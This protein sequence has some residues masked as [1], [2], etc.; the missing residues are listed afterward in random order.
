MPTAIPAL[1]PVESPDPLELFEPA[2]PVELS[3]VEVELDEDPFPDE[4]DE[5]VMD[6]VGV[7]P[8]LDLLKLTTFSRVGRLTPPL[9]NQPPEVGAGQ[10][11]GVTLAS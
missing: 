4:L 8:V 7:D 3:G 5:P 9:T 2:W 1:A 6:A 10:G 11:G